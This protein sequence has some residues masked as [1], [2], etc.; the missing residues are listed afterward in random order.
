MTFSSQVDK[1]LAKATQRSSR[2]VRGTVLGIMRDTIKDTPVD[3]GRL[4][5]NWF[6]SIGSPV[7]QVR[8]DAKTAKGNASKA[9]GAAVS[10]AVDVSTKFKMGQIVYFTNNLPYAATIEFGGMVNGKARAGVGMLRRSIGIRT[11]KLR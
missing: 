10:N 3:T 5:N 9:A 6:A 11:S 2:V 7:N 8:G 4:R 1:A